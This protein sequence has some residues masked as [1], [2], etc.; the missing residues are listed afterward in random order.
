[1]DFTQN[2]YP[3]VF[4]HMK[5]LM[6]IPRFAAKLARIFFANFFSSPL[7]GKRLFLMDADY[8]ADWCI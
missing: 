6:N 8:A 2:F 1:M 4:T 5:G 7:G 3:R